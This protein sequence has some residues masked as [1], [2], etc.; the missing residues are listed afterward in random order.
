MF[1][2]I[3]HSRRYQVEIPVELFHIFTID[4]PERVECIV[5][6]SLWM[7]EASPARLAQMVKFGHLLSD[8]QGPSNLH[9]YYHPN[10]LSEM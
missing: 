8:R 4:S 7:S 3:S 5:L 6:S 9:T 10:L 2:S 1:T